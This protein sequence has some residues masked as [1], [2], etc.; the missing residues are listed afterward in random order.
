MRSESAD[1]G[2]A[3][4]QAHRATVGAGSGHS[5]ARCT[6]GANFRGT[7]SLLA[8]ASGVPFRLISRGT[9]VIAGLKKVG[10]K[11]ERKNR[12][13]LAVAQQGSTTPIVVWLRRWVATCKVA[14]RRPSFRAVSSPLQCPEDVFTISSAGKGMNNGTFNFFLV[15]SSGFLFASGTQ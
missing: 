1:C 4:K 13:R 10:Q 11:Q 15:S 8:V 2:S 12:G 6:G 14:K 5:R 7:L 3:R 9:A